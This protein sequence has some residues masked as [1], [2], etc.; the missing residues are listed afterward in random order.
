MITFLLSPLPDRRMGP[1]GGGHL[2]QRRTR[3]Q[4]RVRP[5]ALIV[6]RSRNG[7]YAPKTIQPP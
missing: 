6:V 5:V 3:H 7:A 1:T 2:A 4:R